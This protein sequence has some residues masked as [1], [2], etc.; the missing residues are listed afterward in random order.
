MAFHEIP[1]G[2]TGLTIEGVANSA[3]VPFT[4]GCGYYQLST[5]DLT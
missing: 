3:G 2:G 4:K 5:F 1:V